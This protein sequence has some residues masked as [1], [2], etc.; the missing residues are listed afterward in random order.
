MS[1]CVF[2]N[3]VFYTFYHNFLILQKIYVCFFLFFIIRLFIPSIPLLWTIRLCFYSI[4]EYR[5]DSDK[6]VLLK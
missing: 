1:V 2:L 4:A 5:F 3:F 6:I